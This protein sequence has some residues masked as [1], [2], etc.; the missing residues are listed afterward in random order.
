MYHHSICHSLLQSIQ[1]N[2]RKAQ[3]DAIELRNEAKSLSAVADL[4]EKACKEPKTL[5][6]VFGINI[7]NRKMDGCFMYNCSRL[8]KMYEKVGPQLEGGV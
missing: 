5:N 4:K 8:I 2:L 7:G 6:F 1:S 3:A